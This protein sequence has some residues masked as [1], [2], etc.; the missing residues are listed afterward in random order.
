MAPFPPQFGS[1][2][3]C[4]TQRGK[5]ADACPP[6]ISYATTGVVPSLTLSGTQK[7]KMLRVIMRG[8]PRPRVEAQQ[9]PLEN[10]SGNLKIGSAEHMGIEDVARCNS[11]DDVFWQKVRL[12]GTILIS[13]VYAI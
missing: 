7:S 13:R 11:L 10:R 12:M 3:R 5:G 1:I 8:F 6:R 4:S 2:R 9:I